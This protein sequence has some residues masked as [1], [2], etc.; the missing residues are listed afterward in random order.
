VP[1]RAMPVKAAAHTGSPGRWPS[2]KGP[3]RV[4]SGLWSRRLR[5]VQHTCSLVQFP[6]K[7]GA[8]PTELLGGSPIPCSLR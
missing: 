4:G 1:Q 7:R 5:I 3:I 6:Y 8:L 2:G